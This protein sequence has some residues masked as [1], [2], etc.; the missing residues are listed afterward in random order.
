MDES[1]LFRHRVLLQGGMYSTHGGWRRGESESVVLKL[2]AALLLFLA[3]CEAI[4]Q[5]GHYSW[6]RVKVCCY[7]DRGYPPETAR[8]LALQDALDREEGQHPGR[9]N[10]GCQRDL[11]FW[12][13]GI[14]QGLADCG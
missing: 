2:A 3:G 4:D 9:C 6:G 8:E 11:H 10:P 7:I 12:R 1:K 5:F 14:A 13:K